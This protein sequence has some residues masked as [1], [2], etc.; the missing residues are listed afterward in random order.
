MRFNYLRVSGDD[1]SVEAQRLALG[2]ADAE[3]ADE[4]V[5]GAVLAAQRPGF[6]AMLAKLR[7][8]DT[9]RVYAVDRLGRD[10]LDVQ[11]TVRRL[12]ESGVTVDVHG[13][14]PGKAIADL[15]AGYGNSDGGSAK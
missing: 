10:A 15:T 6:A 2:A 7:D 14:G 3:F 11:A 5:S 13:L 1:Q 4:G 8:G 9:V 12:I